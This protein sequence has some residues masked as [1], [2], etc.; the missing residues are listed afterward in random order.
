MA[1]KKTIRSAAPT[2]KITASRDMAQA[3]PS[4]G[5]RPMRRPVT[6][7]TSITASVQNR[8]AQASTMSTASLAGLTPEQRQFARQLQMNMRRSTPVTAA[9]NTTNIMARPDFLELLPMFVQKLYILDVYGS[10]AM[11]SRQQLI[12]YFKF[13][14]EN[15]KGETNAGDI[16]SSPFVNRQGIDPNFTGRVVK[17]ELMADGT[18]ITDN[19]A[20]VYTPVLPK[21]VT[22]KY[23]AAGTVT[24]YVDDGNG[25]IVVAGSTTPVG[26]IDYSTGTVSTS[27]LFTPAAGN[28]VKVTYQYDN[29]NVGPRT[30]GNGGYGYE[31]GAQMAKGYLQLDEI[32]LVA[33]AHEL[34]CYW[35]VYSAFAAQ[36]EYGSNIAEMA[37]E[38]AFGEIT[39]EINTAGFAKLAKAASYKPQFNWDAS[40]VL[41]GSVVPSDYLQMF[42]LKLDQAASSIYQATRLAQPNRLIVGTNVNSYL[43]QI[44]GFKADGATDNVGPFK[45]GTLDQ[46]EVY[47]D[48]NY[49]PDT[50]VMCCKSNDIRRNSALYGEYMPLVST[51]AIGLANASV[52]QGY[53]TMYAMDIVN[54]ATVVSGKILGVF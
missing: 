14:A 49:N 13:I 29:E 39:A 16:L 18:E 37:K 40:P 46:F 27:G 9:T 53:A 5:T 51:D 17:N 50:W 2:R 19:L 30:P 54:P 24:D 47:C 12:P 6:A 8:K 41:N 45:A 23:D 25:N 10:V 7:G 52:Q 34:A 26:Y 11:R 3:R 31:Y 36:Q 4:F 43:K 28:N 21:S 38:A 1:I 42:K 44:N 15:T 20:I 48:P 35:S 22:I 32:N 33:E